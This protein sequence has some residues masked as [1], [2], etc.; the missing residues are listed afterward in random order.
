MTHDARNLKYPI[1]LFAQRWW[2]S[3]KPVITYA[4]AVN[5]Q[6]HIF[7]FLFA[8]PFQLLHSMFFF[9]IH[10]ELNSIFGMIGKMKKKYMY[11]H[12]FFRMMFT[13]SYFWP[14]VPFLTTK[15][16]VWYIYLLCFW[17]CAII[18]TMSCISRLLS[19]QFWLGFLCFPLVLIHES[20]LITLSIAPAGIGGEEKGEG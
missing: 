16:S 18:S 12:W 13:T 9:L 3:H 8:S 1:Y 7:F 15:Y 19:S 17:V 4:M 11:S 20:T 2:N 14:T 6:M 5:L 10:V